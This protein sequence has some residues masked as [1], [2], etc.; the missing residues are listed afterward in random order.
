MDRVTKILLII[1]FFV[2]ISCIVTF[3]MAFLGKASFYTS[4]I[5]ALISVTIF[6]IAFKL[7]DCKTSQSEYS[8]D[9]K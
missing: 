2:Y 7:E 5:L 6:V 1:D 8:S 4:L 9:N 3:F